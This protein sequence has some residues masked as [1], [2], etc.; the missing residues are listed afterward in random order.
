M[1]LYLGAVSVHAA[2]GTQGWEGQCVPCEEQ[3]D[4]TSAAGV[5]LTGFRLLWVL[6]TWLS[7][8]TALPPSERP[9][10]ERECSSHPTRGN[11]PDIFPSRAIP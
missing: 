1:Q 4:G 5:G 11:L 9:L 8:S 7:K 10:F 3:S 2:S 6:L